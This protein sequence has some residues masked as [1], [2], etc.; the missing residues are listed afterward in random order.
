MRAGRNTSLA[1]PTASHPQGTAGTHIRPGEPQE[2]P[3][4]DMAGELM[5]MTDGDHLN[6]V[7]A[8]FMPYCRSQH[9]NDFRPIEESPLEQ[10]KQTAP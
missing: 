7:G 2:D 9:L 3:R 10:Y 1:A 6:R 5:F 4:T 8:F